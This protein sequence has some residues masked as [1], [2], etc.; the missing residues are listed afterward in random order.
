MAAETSRSPS[1]VAAPPVAATPGA[2]AAT[3]IRVYNDA[4]SNTLKSCNYDNFAACFPTPAKNVPDALQGLH[5][6]FVERLEQHCKSEF[7]AI[8]RERNVVPSLNDLDRL[9]EDARRRKARAEEQANGGVVKAPIPPHTLPA[10]SLYLA[11]LGSTVETRHTQLTSQLEKLQTQNQDLLDTLAKQRAEIEQ[12]IGSVESVI[13]DLDA[14]L[15]ALPA[16]E[17]QSMTRDAVALDTEI[18]AGD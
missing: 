1:P 18:R 15:Q 9:I 4:V 6:D 8:L 7:E 13:A 10:R 11:H 3:L 17:M 12:T 14:S 2:R 5:K 16:E